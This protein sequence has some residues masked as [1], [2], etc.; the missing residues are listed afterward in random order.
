VLLKADESNEEHLSSSQIA[1]A[2]GVYVEQV[3]A[4]GLHAGQIVILDKLSV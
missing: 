2:F 1:A 4:S 3:L